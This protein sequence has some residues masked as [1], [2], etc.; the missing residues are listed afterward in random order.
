MIAA[1]IL[2]VIIVGIII[3]GF[4]LYNLA[5]QKESGGNIGYDVVSK[6]AKNVTINIIFADIA[7]NKVVT[8]TV[9]ERVDLLPE[10]M[11]YIEF[12]S[13]YLRELTIPK[14][15]VDTTILIEWGEDEQL[16]TLTSREHSAATE[17]EKREA[18]RI[19]EE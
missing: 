13:E 19:A 2:G 5:E 10:G 16:R 7:H 15:V 14:T 8:K 17:K 1:I 11:Q 4:S 18:L 9:V 12:D 6:E 3:G